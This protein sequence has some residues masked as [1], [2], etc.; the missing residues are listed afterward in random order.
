MLDTLRS[1]IALS[2]FSLL[3]A[4]TAPGQTPAPAPPAPTPDSYVT[5]K[6]FRS[7]VFE[8]KH[9]DPVTLYES[10]RPLASGFKGAIMSPNRELSTLAVRDFPEN[11]ATIEESLRRLDVPETRQSEVQLRLWVLHASS[12]PTS[13][14]VPEDLKEVIASLKSTLLYKGYDVAATFEQRVKDGTRN[15]EGAGVGEALEPPTPK[16]ER[17]A[18]R[19][20]Y[21]VGRLQV[22]TP[23]TGPATIRL[24]GFEFGAYH[25]QGRAVIRTDLSLR[26]GEKVVVGTSTLKDRALVVVLVAKIAK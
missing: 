15:L 12:S 8:V 24:T 25:Y 5:E 20:E 3:P 23:A 1:A 17:P 14:P 22:D 2:L 18:M 10:L 6:G 21:K 4:L 13:S 26:D 7:R 9:R 16:G 11:L 19:L